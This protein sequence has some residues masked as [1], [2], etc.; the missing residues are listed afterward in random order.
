[1]KELVEYYDDLTLGGSLRTT[2]N[3]R[4][5]KTR[6]TGRTGK[7]RRT[8]KNRKAAGFS[9]TN[10]TTRKSSKEIIKSP[11]SAK[12]YNLIEGLIINTLKS[13]SLEEFQTINTMPLDDYPLNDVEIMSTSKSDTLKSVNSKSKS[14]SVIKLNSV[15]SY[16]Y[17]SINYKNTTIQDKLYIDLVRRRHN[18]IQENHKKILTILDLSTSIKLKEKKTSKSKKLS[19]TLKNKTISKSTS[20]TSIMAL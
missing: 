10:T 17:K 16:N 4:T 7:T 9:R 13:L 3:R 8:D 11:L 2:R 5:G 1:M 6:R 20:P 18:K 14:K 19:G 12:L 15:V